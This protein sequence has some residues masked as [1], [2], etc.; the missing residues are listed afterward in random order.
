MIKA[1]M[2]KEES[3]RLQQQHG[4]LNLV[5]DGRLVFPPVARL[6]DALDLGYGGA[7]WAFELAD[8]HPECQV[9]ITPHP[10]GLELIEPD[11]GSRHI[12]AY[13]ARRNARQLRAPGRC[14]LLL[15]SS[16]ETERCISLR[17]FCM[18][19]LSSKLWPRR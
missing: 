1:Y 9:L 6:Y 7:T 10:Y 15:S 12:L 16:G 5:F 18:R 13:G 8:E 11:R 2:M 17:G 19:V 3:E 14:F 4:V